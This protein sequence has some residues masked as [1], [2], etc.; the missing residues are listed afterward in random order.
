MKATGLHWHDAAFA[1][2]DGGSLVSIAPSIVRADPA[3]PHTIGQPAKTIARL[4]PRLVSAEHWAAIAR[5]GQRVTPQVI[6]VARGELAQRIDGPLRARPLQCAVSATYD[7]ALGTLLAIGR[8]E[9]LA[10]GGFHDAAVLAVAATGLQSATLVLELGLAH[11]AVTRVECGD[12]E[13]RRHTAVVRRGVGLLALQQRWLRMIAEAMV[14]AT[15]FDPLHDGASEQRLFDALERAAAHAAE[16]GSCLVELPTAGEPASVEL[17]RDR[18]VESSADILRGIAGAVRDLRPAGQPVNLLCDESLLQVPGMLEQLAELRE[19]RLLTHSSGLVA[20]AASLLTEQADEN[21]VVTLQR[22]CPLSTVLEPAREAV[23]LNRV[24][25]N[26]R[27]PT[28]ALWDGRAVALPSRGALEIGR[29]VGAEGIRL[30]EGLT[31][32]SRLHC[33]LRTESGQVTLIPHTA[34]AIWLN[35]ERVQG[36]VPV[37]SKDRLRLGSPGVIIDL[38]AVGELRDGPSPQH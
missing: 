32:V 19:C 29:D 8:L 28:H 25:V 22:G 33:S 11:A 15:R 9:G 24:S 4:S 37:R 31:G 34:Q 1:L 23:G 13:A 3:A 2:A 12:N 14:S 35:D 27:P 16:S 6:N 26:D 30:A 10:I 20:R 38:I 21:G 17:G 36:R 18:F 5:D 7:H